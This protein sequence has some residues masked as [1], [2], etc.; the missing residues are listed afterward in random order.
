M[1]CH[2]SL[3][4]VLASLCLAGCPDGKGSG[5][6][7]VAPATS[8]APAGAYDD[9]KVGQVYQSTLLGGA[10]R[11]D[12]VIARLTTAIVVARRVTFQKKANEDVVTQAIPFQQ[13]PLPEGCSRVEVKKDTLTISGRSFPCTVW[14]LRIKTGNKTE[15]ASKDWI[16]DRYPFLLRRMGGGF[17]V[18]ELEGIEDKPS[19]PDLP[20][21]AQEIK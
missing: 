1:R 7:A 18:E 6:D 10:T 17:V 13:D 21:G 12:E 19:D 11:R 16:S 20:K 3:L 9:V 8:G 14:E 15:V 2:L 5:T 4:L